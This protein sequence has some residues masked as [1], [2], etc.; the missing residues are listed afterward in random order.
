MS[1]FSRW[2]CAILILLAGAWPLTSVSAW[3]TESLL[4]GDPSTRAIYLLVNG[5]KRLV[6]DTATLE[7]LGFALR[8][9]RWL[10][11]YALSRV[12]TGPNLLPF[13]WGDLLQGEQGGGVFVL[14]GGKRAIPDEETLRAL[15]WAERPVKPA[16]RALLSVI[17]EASPLPAL[18]S[19]DLIQCEGTG[20]LYV[21]AQGRHWFPD[22]AALA[23]GGWERSRVH[24][25][26]A[27]LMALV[28]EGDVVPTLYPGCLV[29]S[30]DEEDERVYILDRGKHLIPDEE[31][32]A[33]YGWLE[34]RI[35]RLPP[36]LLEAIPDQ[37][38][39]MSVARGENLFAY[40]HWGQCTWY[41]AERRIAP[42]WRDAK[43]WYADAIKA[44]YAVGQV[45]LPG[46]ILVYDSGQGRGSYGHVAYVETVYPDGSFV[47]A[48]SNICGWECVRRRVTDLSKEVGVLG[49]VY[50]KYDGER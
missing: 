45:P 16:T 38:P 36:D 10:T 4:V 6:P 49:F 22:E 11:S 2:V 30:V 34:S 42:S 18:R 35:W 1:P 27:A 44:G 9:V 21:L 29:G 19:G 40:E 41:V 48:D 12:A 7:V 25:L 39:L 13:K 46:A 33:A 47:R 3:E 26:S 20:C 24:D 15:G 14:D 37:S 32:W 28:P 8:E 23:A 31:T 43:Y 17:P 5:Q 50:W